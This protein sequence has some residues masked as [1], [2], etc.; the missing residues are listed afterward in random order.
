MYDLDRIEIVGCNIDNTE[1]LFHKSFRYCFQC[2]CCLKDPFCSFP[3]RLYWSYVKNFD[4]VHSSKKEVLFLLR[5]C[6]DH[7]KKKMHIRRRDN[8]VSICL[9][10]V[11]IFSFLHLLTPSVCYFLSVHRYL[12]F[13]SSSSSCLQIIQIVCG[14]LALHSLHGVSVFL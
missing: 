6:V 10:S 13:P 9:C 14:L 8:V 12:F 2:W 11:F 3:S 7:P 5:C 1:Y 4:F